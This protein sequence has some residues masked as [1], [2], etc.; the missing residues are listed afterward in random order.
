M[1]VLIEAISV[2][3]K[4]EAIEEKFDGGWKAFVDSI[5]N[6]TFCSDGELARIG[7]LDPADVQTYI[8][9]LEASGLQII[10]DS[11]FIDGAVIDQQHGPTLRCDWLEFAKLNFAERG[12]VSACWLFEGPRICSGLH[13]R[14]TQMSL[15]TPSGWIYEGSLSETFLFVSTSDD[16]NHGDRDK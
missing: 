5:P 2:V 12:K 11:E 3:V 9:F 15:A 4:C 13:L 14:S 8:G 7:F 1:A 6:A 10:A 16:A